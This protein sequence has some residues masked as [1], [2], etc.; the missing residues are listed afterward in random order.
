MSGT[1]VMPELTK[2]L[3]DIRQEMRDMRSA[4]EKELRKEFKD[5]KHSID[6]FSTQFDAMTTRCAAIEKENV[7]LKKENTALT[8]KCQELVGQVS[9]FEERVTTQE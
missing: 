6:F 8:A 4:I 9:G 2:F 1:R 7:S 5:M 3:K